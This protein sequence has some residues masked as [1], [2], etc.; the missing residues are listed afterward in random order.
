MDKN[1]TKIAKE[2]K[3]GISTLYQWKKTRPELYEYLIRN[4]EIQKNE[5]TELFELLE[6]EEQEMYLTEMKARIL[7]KKLR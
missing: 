5:I 6:K 7:R 3:I 1:I 4:S 2:L